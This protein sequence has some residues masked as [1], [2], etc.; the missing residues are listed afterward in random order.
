MLEAIMSILFIIAWLGVVLGILLV[1]NTLC[2]TVSNVLFNGEKFSFKRLFIGIGKGLVFYIGSAL[3]CVAF[4]ILPFI[5]EMITTSFNTVLI[6]NDLLSTLSSV[7]ILA[8]IVTAIVTQGKNAI[9]SIS[10]LAN[11]TVITATQKEDK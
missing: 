4:T 1:T 7:G 9:A 2:G 6:S 8:M 11:A 3:T 5:N 10:K